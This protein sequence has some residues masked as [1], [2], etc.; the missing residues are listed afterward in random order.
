MQVNITSQEKP[1]DVLFMFP[2]RGLA[3]IAC[4]SMKT[5]WFEDKKWPRQT[6]HPDWNYGDSYQNY[7]ELRWQLPN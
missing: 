5:N 6:P 4:E 3:E 2:I 1:I 7:G